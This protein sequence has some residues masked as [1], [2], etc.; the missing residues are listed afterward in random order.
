MNR[1]KEMDR[2]IVN[3]E[4][5]TLND[6]TQFLELGVAI[7]KKMALP[8]KDMTQQT[9][10]L[11]CFFCSE[12]R[13]GWR[14]SANLSG[15]KDTDMQTVSQHNP[16]KVNDRERQRSDFEKL[17]CRPRWTNKEHKNKRPLLPAHLEQTKT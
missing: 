1:K 9:V 4:H 16:K 7:G 13:A 15:G 8:K 14:M 17:M 12:E 11:T 2:R 10:T 3:S 6:P 5:V